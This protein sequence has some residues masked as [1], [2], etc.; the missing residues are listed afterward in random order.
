MAQFE[1]GEQ[2][3]LSREWFIHDQ[4]VQQALGQGDAAGSTDAYL[5]GP[6]IYPPVDQRSSQPQSTS[7]SA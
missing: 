1:S 7:G 2:A 5:Q 6:A 4:R 3:H